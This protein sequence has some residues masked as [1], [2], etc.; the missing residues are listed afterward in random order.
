[1]VKRAISSTPINT[2]VLSLSTFLLL[3]LSCGND[4]KNIYVDHVSGEVFIEQGSTKRAL[5]LNTIITDSEP[6]E[7]IDFENGFSVFRVD[8]TKLI[9][10][11]QGKKSYTFRE[12]LEEFDFCKKN[13]NQRYVNYITRNIN[14]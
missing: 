11:K 14:I 3:F 7:T 5:T 1:M 6:F 2:W 9:L 12:L 13:I 10:P 4:Q 8:S